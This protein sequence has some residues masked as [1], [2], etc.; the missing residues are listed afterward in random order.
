MITNLLS[1]I[2]WMG[3]N[4][5]EFVWGGLGILIKT[6][7]EEPYYSYVIIIILLIAMISLNL[8]VIYFYI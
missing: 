1:A 2:P 3:V 5:V 6:L 8:G 7:I 4:I